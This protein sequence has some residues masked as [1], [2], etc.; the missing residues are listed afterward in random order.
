MP[1]P[2]EKRKD[3]EEV[4]LDSPTKKKNK[5]ATKLPFKTALT[6]DDY[7]QIAARLKDEMDDTFQAMQASQGKLQGAIDQQLVV[8]KTLTEKTAMI[9]TQLIKSPTG[10]I[11]T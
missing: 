4:P 7:E 11:L 2:G 8:L 5:K 3:P 1:L 10:Y 9:H 6:D